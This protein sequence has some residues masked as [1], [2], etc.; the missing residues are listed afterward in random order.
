MEILWLLHH[1]V[2]IAAN[3]SKWVALW[4]KKTPSG[5]L[6][7]ATIADTLTSNRVKPHNRKPGTQVDAARRRARSGSS[8]G[9]ST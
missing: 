2:M 9:S 6:A 7:S 5:S 1:F 8:S 4:G 3:R